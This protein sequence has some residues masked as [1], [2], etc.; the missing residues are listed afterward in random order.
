[1]SREYIKVPTF[2]KI[3]RLKNNLLG[4]QNNKRQ[5]LSR[6]IAAAWQ[7]FLPPLNMS[8]FFADFCECRG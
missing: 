4:T 6:K 1:V 5:N 7:M 2:I 3:K 8:R